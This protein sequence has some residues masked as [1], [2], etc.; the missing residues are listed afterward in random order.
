[1]GVLLIGQWKK[2]GGSSLIGHSFVYSAMNPHQQFMISVTQPLWT[3]KQSISCTFIEINLSG[4]ENPSFHIPRVSK[5]GEVF[6]LM[7]N[8]AKERGWR[9]AALLS[10]ASRRSRNL[11]SFNCQT[12]RIEPVLVSLVEVPCQIFV[13]ETPFLLLEAPLNNQYL[14][15]DLA[16]HNN[17]L[18]FQN[19]HIEIVFVRYFWSLLL[20]AI[21]SLPFP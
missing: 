21:P 4:G 10:W 9:V 17:L 16:H 5:D 11:S 1:M 3:V 19:V 14:Q 6:V 8:S 13:A 7:A 18:K 20:V 15:T 12:P 2:D